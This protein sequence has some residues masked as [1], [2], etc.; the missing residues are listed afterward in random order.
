MTGCVAI[1]GDCVAS[2]MSWGDDAGIRD[3][4]FCSEERLAWS[5]VAV[6]RLGTPRGP[7]VR[8][9]GASA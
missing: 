3:K 8:S 5:Q 7:L 2:L 9:C 4:L 6:F 1:F